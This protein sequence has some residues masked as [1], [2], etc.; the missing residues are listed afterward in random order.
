MWMASLFTLCNP[1]QGKAVPLFRGP[2]N[3]EHQ[4]SSFCYS[5]ETIIPQRTL[6]IAFSVAAN[7]LLNIV[8]CSLSMYNNTNTIFIG[9]STQPSHVEIQVWH[10][11]SEEIHDMLLQSKT[12]QKVR[13]KC[14][15]YGKQS[16]IVYT[17]N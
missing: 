16:Y 4:Q 3:N 7:F 6:T 11:H 13:S 14:Q 15:G 17:S 2:A 8:N 1:K 5:I 10:T 12:R 9:V